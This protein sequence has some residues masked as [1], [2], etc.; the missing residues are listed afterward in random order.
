VLPYRA[1]LVNIEK[2]QAI[3]FCLYLIDKQQLFILINLEQS[4]LE[5]THN[6]KVVSSNLAPATNKY[7]GL[8][9]CAKPFVLSP[10]V[11]ARPLFLDKACG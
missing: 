10:E 5:K 3:I 4:L 1:Q 8:A 6:L 7:K 9:L 11:N 2:S